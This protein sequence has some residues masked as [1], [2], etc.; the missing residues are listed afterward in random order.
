MALIDYADRMFSMY[1]DL[2]YPAVSK[3]SSDSCYICISGADQESKCFLRGKAVFREAVHNN[4]LLNAITV[5]GTNL[6]NFTVESTARLESKS[7]NYTK[8]RKAAYV[9]KIRSGKNRNVLSEGDYSRFMSFIDDHD[10]FADLEEME[11]DDFALD[12]TDYQFAGERGS[13]VLF[14]DPATPVSTR[15]ANDLAQVVKNLK[16]QIATP[17]PPG[18]KVIERV[19]EIKVPHR[20][21]FFMELV[22][23]FAATFAIAD[24]TLPDFTGLSLVESAIVALNFLRNHATTNLEGSKVIFRSFVKRNQQVRQGLARAKLSSAKYETYMA[25]LEKAYASM[26]K[27]LFDGILPALVSR[28][29]PASFEEE[30]TGPLNL[31]PIAPG[32]MWA[33]VEGSAERPPMTLP[34]Y[35][36]CVNPRSGTANKLLQLTG[37]TTAELQLMWDNARAAAAAQR[38]LANKCLNPSRGQV[39]SAGAGLLRPTKENSCESPALKLHKNLGASA[40]K[41]K[42]KPKRKVATPESAISGS[43]PVRVATRVGYV[44]ANGFEFHGSLHCQDDKVYI[45]TCRHAC[46]DSDNGVVV[47]ERPPCD[48]EATIRVPCSFDI[49]HP[50]QLTAPKYATVNKDVMRY[51]VIGFP[52]GF[53][54]SLSTSFIGTAPEEGDVVSCTYYRSGEWYE[55][56]STVDSVL[57]NLVKVKATTYDGMC[58]APWTGPKGL[59]GG[60]TYGNLTADSGGKANGFQI[61]STANV[62]PFA[63]KVEWAQPI[64]TIRGVPSIQGGRKY[65]RRVLAK[66]LGNTFK[67]RCVALGDAKA[68]EYIMKVCP[69]CATLCH[70]HRADAKPSQRDFDLVDKK[71]FFVL[72]DNEYDSLSLVGNG[73]TNEEVER[74]LSYY[75]VIDARPALQSNCE[76]GM[77]ELPEKLKAKFSKPESQTYMLTEDCCTFPATHVWRKPA[78]FEVEKEL[79]KFSESTQ[80]TPLEAMLHEQVVWREI[81]D[82]ER[83]HAKNY[84]PATDPNAIH[85]MIDVVATLHASSSVG[86]YDA[87]SPGGRFIEGHLCVDQAD[88]IT[89]MGDGCPASGLIEVAYQCLLILQE[90]EKREGPEVYWSVQGK[91]DKYK[92]EP[93]DEG[94]EVRKARSIQAPPLFFKAIWAY[95][96]YES[97][98]SWTEDISSDYFLKWNPNRPIQKRLWDAMKS[99]SYVASTDVTG[100]DRR[101]PARLIEDFF[102]IYVASM[103]FGISEN[104]L[105][106]MQNAT[107][108]SKMV[109]ANGRVLQKHR[110][111]PS[112]FP[113]TIRLNCLTHKV[114]NTVC[115]R[116]TGIPGSVRSFYVGDDG[117]NF[118]FDA[119]GEDML[120]Q[121]LSQWAALYP[122]VVKLEGEWKPQDGD[123]SNLPPFVSRKPM[124]LFPGIWFYGLSNPY[125]V[126]TKLISRD[127]GEYCEEDYLENLQSISMSLAHHV[128]T[129]TSGQKYL[130]F[131]EGMLETADSRGQLDGVVR[132][133]WSTV[134]SL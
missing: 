126:M 44:E 50:V 57:P 69:F 45:T 67:S 54:K 71:K 42:P 87:F 43:V 46:K 7:R 47:Y 24:S 36:D 10:F 76:A 78:A 113:N 107:I 53:K 131:V 129:H 60:H 33:D 68:M 121:A 61:D 1:H 4:I 132:S 72:T 26:E 77:E 30:A 31:D 18:G 105:L 15:M 108:H 40:R 106:W 133:A 130:D 52:D 3:T 21:T 70:L 74:R 81:A 37:K 29:P 58:R 25:N 97:D 100:W 96:M 23:A 103:C 12:I 20:G 114:V 84:L 119:E 104:V 134:T 80:P 32:T 8:K 64:I 73:S 118:A 11:E 66:D 112:G 111:N 35:F 123:F 110:G 22:D 83:C 94:Y 124:Q 2:G 115:Q 6:V 38:A 95:C 48:G 86:R 99:A 120:K 92:L 55:T 91:R 51:Q 13:G 14:A 125:K 128:V 116:M 127:N 109:L 9:S 63:N 27:E 98:A 59:V 117:L 85:R 65:Q 39:E 34:T 82:E 90:V 28:K 5:A 89:Q 56:R 49:P 102:G 19:K 101:L 122:W 17:P 16:K 75:T 93:T 41:P 62:G 79:W 88:F